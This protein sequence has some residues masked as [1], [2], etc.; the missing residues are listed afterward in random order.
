MFYHLLLL[1]DIVCANEPHDKRRRRLRSVIRCIPG[2]ADIGRREKI[3][4][5]A[6]NA[7][8]LLRDRF[9]GAIAQ[10]WEGL[11]LK[12]CDDPYF[13][14]DGSVRQIKLRKT[15]FEDWVIRQTWRLSAGGETPGT[16]MSHMRPRM[17]SPRSIP[18]YF[19]S[20]SI[21]S[22]ADS[23]P[24]R[25]ASN[26]SSWLDSVDFFLERESAPLLL[27]RVLLRFGDWLRRWWLIGG[28]I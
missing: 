11:A 21:L 13:S 27:P 14:F 19:S 26:G 22:L 7:A 15:T 9:A 8:N 5:G 4:F 10:G 12:G 2:R 3:D 1:D 16:S 6:S 17:C 25:L 24:G 28:V 20:P 23:F 18:R